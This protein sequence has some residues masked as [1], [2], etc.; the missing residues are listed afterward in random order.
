MCSAI[1]S[2]PS[3]SIA[4]GRGG[5]REQGGRW[6]EFTL[7]S[8]ACAERTT[9]TRSVNGVRRSRARCAAHGLASG[10]AGEEGLGVGR[11]ACGPAPPR[12]PRRRGWPR[13]R[14][15]HVSQ[16]GPP[17]VRKPGCSRTHARPSRR[18]STPTGR[19]AGAGFY[20]GDGEACPPSA[21]P[22]AAP[23]SCLVG[24]W[25]V[26]GFFGLDVGLLYLDLSGPRAAGRRSGASTSGS[27]PAALHV[28]RIGPD[29]AVGTTGGS[30]PTGCASTWTTRRAA[31]AS[32]PWPRTAAGSPSAS[33]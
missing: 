26:T 5:G 9:A 31:T 6:R 8:V 2:S 11:A 15:A 7:T 33:S 28:R 29:G 18:S 25:P 17:G 19:S 12:R 30:S 27:T 3:A 4:R 16:G 32:S 24:A 23:F 21:L 1:P 20:R 13:T 14:A 22:W 10:Q